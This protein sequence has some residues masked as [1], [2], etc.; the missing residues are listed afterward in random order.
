MSASNLPTVR[1]EMAHKEKFG[2]LA[3]K[4]FDIQKK[5]VKR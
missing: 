3:K 2:V 1:K 4:Q 5:G